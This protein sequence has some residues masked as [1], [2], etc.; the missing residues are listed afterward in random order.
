MFH[1]GLSHLPKSLRLTETYLHFWQASVSSA[2]S[3]ALMRPEP[4][5]ISGREHT[6]WRSVFLSSFSHRCS[7]FLSRRSY[8]K[9]VSDTASRSCSAFPFDRINL[10]KSWRDS[11]RSLVLPRPSM[12][13]SFILV[14]V[15]LSWFPFSVDTAM[16]LA[17]DVG[18]HSSSLSR[19]STWREYW[20]KG[21]VWISQR[22][23]FPFLLTFC[24]VV[25]QTDSILRINEKRL[26]LERKKRTRW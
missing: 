21:F 18:S 10:F 5:G 4:P 19:L 3:D 15:L 6:R 22:T 20:I 12:S 17:I 7:R 16:A 25:K 13:R 2:W 23:C 9:T 11:P 8:R 1:L 14:V 26:R 24:Y